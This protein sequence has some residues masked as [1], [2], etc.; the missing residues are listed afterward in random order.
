MTMQPF[1]MVEKAVREII[2]RYEPA[3][4]N[5]GGDL[6]Y[7]GK[8]LYVWLGMVPGGGRTDELEGE[9]TIDI[10]C[11]AP[12]YGAAMKAALDLEAVLLARRHVTSVMRIDRTYQNSAPAQRP[13]DDEATFRIGATYTFT[14]RRTG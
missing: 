13:W 12:T 9:W 10:D 14:A 7:S 1:G 11:F 2:E 6:S 3:Q 8:P 4:G 5:V